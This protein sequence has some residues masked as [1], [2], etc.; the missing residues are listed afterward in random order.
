MSENASNPKGPGECGSWMDK[1][2]ACKV[3]GGEIPHGHTDDC[4]ILK[5]ERE[6]RAYQECEK[7]AA[8]LSCPTHGLV[9]NLASFNNKCPNCKV[10]HLTRERDLWQAR[11]MALFY[12]GDPDKTTC[13][14]I[15]KA[16]DAYNAWLA[17][18]SQSSDETT[19][20][21]MTRAEADAMNRAFWRSVEIIDDIDDRE[22]V[23]PGDARYYRPSENPSICPYGQS[24]CETTRGG[25]CRCAMP[26]EQAGDAG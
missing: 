9:P 12:G 24:D 26:A 13:S 2:G 6:L 16:A 21:R 20:R 1:W 18:R 10:E 8:P 4:D 23:A 25:V 22:E 3:C 19:A 7:L 5:M 15:R 17:E 11:A 14:D